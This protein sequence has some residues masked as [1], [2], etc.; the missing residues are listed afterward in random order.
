TNAAAS[1]A[2]ANLAKSVASSAAATDDAR[3]FLTEASV[4]A[5]AAGEFK[6]PAQPIEMKPGANDTTVESDGGMYFDADE[7]VFVFMKNVRVSDPRFSLSGANELKIFI[8]KKTEAAPDK[9]VKPNTKENPGLGLGAKF[10]DVEKIVANGAVRIIQKST[11]AG[12]EPVEASGAIFTYQ[13]K[14]GEII[15]SGGFPWV[16]QGTNV[17]RAKEPN[18]TLR[19][20]KNGSFVTQGNWQINGNLDQKR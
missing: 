6:A 2:Q 17:M 7:G 15:I 19:I 11:E 5:P 20:Q 10:G 14:I 12:K 4:D 3:K 16:K 1:V 8:A 13:P 9:A 18:L